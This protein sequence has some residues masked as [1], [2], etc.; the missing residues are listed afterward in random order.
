[1]YKNRK[2]LRIYGVIRLTFI[3]TFAALKGENLL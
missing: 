2:Y 3:I 1:M